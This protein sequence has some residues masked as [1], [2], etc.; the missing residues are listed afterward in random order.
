MAITVNSTAFRESYEDTL[1]K[2]CED[3]FAQNLAALS[4]VVD[5]TGAALKFNVNDICNTLTNVSQVYR[6]A[7][8]DE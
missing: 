4:T 7:H 8:Q 6:R 3:L 5:E 1:T 2:V